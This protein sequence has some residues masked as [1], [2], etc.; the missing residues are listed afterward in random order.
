MRAMKYISIAIAAAVFFFVI[1]IFPSIYQ[2]T[3]KN[4][5][6]IDWSKVVDDPNIHLTYELV[7]TATY[8]AQMLDSNA[9][10][11]NLLEEHFN[12]TL[13]YSTIDPV[14][15]NRK[16]P[17]SLASG[18]IPDVFQQ[19][20][21]SLKHSA[22]HG[23][24]IPLP[25][26]V[27]IK[28]APTYVKM[29]NHN[30]DLAW[31][32]G[33]VKDQ[34]YCIPNISL[35]GL[36]PTPGIWRKDW[37]EAVGINKV[38]DTIKEYE[39]AFNLFKHQKPDAKSFLAA[40]G[41]VLSSNQR[42][43]ILNKANPTWGMSGDIIN[44]RTGMF[45][46]IFG[47][48]DIQPFQWI[49]VN[50]SIEWGGIQN[51]AKQALEKLKEWYQA[52][53]IHPDFAQDHHSREV[54]QKIYSSVTGYI[55]FWATYVELHPDRERIRTMGNLQRERDKEM[56]ANLGVSDS[57]T[58]TLL[59][60]AN[61]NGRYKNLWTTAFIPAGPNGHRGNRI[62]GTLEQNNKPFVFGKQMINQPEK[63]IR[64]L[65][66]IETALNDD[67]LMTQIT[68]G[69]EG[70][71][72]SWQSP[73]SELDPKIEELKF[74]ER[75]E[76]GD[77]YYSTYDESTAVALPPYHGWLKRIRQG[78]VYDHWNAYNAPILGIPLSENLKQ[79]Y[80]SK[81]QLEWQKTYR[82]KKLGDQCVF[83]DAESLAPEKLI[84]TIKR[85]IAFQQSAY[86]EFIMGLRDLNDWNEFVLEFQ[87]I[88]GLEA[89]LRMRKHYN[90]IQMINTRVDS[91]LS[92]AN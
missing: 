64:W 30:T 50:G 55:A 49:F 69:K 13:N 22:K 12:I 92:L 62:S 26:S 74:V 29:I 17:L 27:L 25:V 80:Q 67:E 48:Y 42:Q 52:G 78:L 37:L 88:G 6:N 56:L 47:A 44:W 41:D 54:F 24:I 43:L 89:M 11:K 86:A 36:Q 76:Y 4:S 7:E 32:A 79:R 66:M 16:G 39:L 20:F 81:Q 18:I 61:S 73:D 53:F 35:S 34:N 57:N 91:L 33:R 63:V 58:E 72:W 1:L 87:N 51:E 14:S 45:T 68:I 15:Y 8:E 10:A 84:P 65:R 60:E 5:Y 46:E 21:T 31:M 3:I 75:N 28:Y 71:H 70:L 19:P 82:K 59:D 9:Y 38:P 90:D 2:H 83:G 85:L 77:M 40:F 23:F